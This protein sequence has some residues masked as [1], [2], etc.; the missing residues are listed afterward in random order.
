MVD[1]AIENQLGRIQ[2]LLILAVSLLSGLVFGR[3]YGGEAVL[4]VVSFAVLGV[5]MLMIGMIQSPPE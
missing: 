5:A 4:A 1:V 3:D 2:F